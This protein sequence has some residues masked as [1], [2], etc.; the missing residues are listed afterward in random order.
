M[1]LQILMANNTLEGG[2]IPNQ[3]IDEQIA[4]LNNA[5]LPAGFSFYVSEVIRT[6]DEHWYHDLR[7]NTDVEDEVI[8]LKKGGNATLNVYSFG[9]NFDPGF[10][11]ATLPDE[12]LWQPNYDGVFLHRRAWRGGDYLGL[13]LGGTLVHEVGHWFGLHHTV[14]F[15]C[16]ETITDE[17]DDTPVEL[18]PEKNGGC[19]LGRDSCPNHPG[20]DLIHN[21][22]GFSIDTCRGDFTPGQ[23][24]RMKEQVARFRQVAYPG[25]NVDEVPIIEA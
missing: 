20:I 1:V 16:E 6:V 10:S 18:A 5:F 15:D 23:I 3:L 11:W 9:T 25:I 21:W 22:M 4:Y 19:E 13:Q 7:R 8:M 17:V 14:S 2:D 24:Q 12:L